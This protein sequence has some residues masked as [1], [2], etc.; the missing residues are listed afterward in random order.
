MRK[1]TIS[2]LMVA[3]L[4]V[5]LVAGCA[6][7]AVAPSTSA[8]TP[9]APTPQAALDF[10]VVSPLTGPMAD[11]GTNMKNG[12]L[13]A[14]EDQNQEGGVTVAGQKYTINAV[15]RDSKADVVVG[16][17][18]AEEL[19][20]DK[21]IKVIGGPF[22]GD[23]VGVQSITEKNKVI[24][25]FLVALISGIIGPNKPFSFFYGQGPLSE[26][27]L[28]SS[29]TQKFY[30]EAKTV[31]S[32][33]TDVADLPVF[34][35]AAK[36]MAE[37]YGLNWLGYEKCPLTTTDFTPIITRVLAKKPDIVDTSN[38]GGILGGQ[39][40][41]MV[42]QLRQQGF[43]GIIWIPA[44]PPPGALQEVVPR[45]YLN[46]IV[47][48]SI[49]L[50]SPIVA[51]AF[52]DLGK[53]YQKEYNQIPAPVI[54]MAYDP[55]K[56]FFEFLNTQDTMDTT[57]WME[58]FAKYHWQGIWGKEAFWVGKPLYGIDRILLG[59]RWV[60]EWTDGKLD[61]KWEAPLPLE[62]WIEQ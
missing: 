57:T 30:P 9:S 21:K 3:I 36:S 44:P 52:R 38:V 33:I 1:S 19:V 25:F 23:A 28:A 46:R 11:L 31:V 12:I 58:G 8:P 39:C 5:V 20:F 60:S 43:E 27:L 14:I 22:M 61:T 55:I 16:R 6:A 18:I 7:P 54:A 15:V 26:V 48:L 42:K 32:I 45:E 35:D 13:M 53:R 17:N 50:D 41:V 34:A 10:G 24:S 59:S 4:A 62:L 40:A 2:I 29:Y 49:N 51:Q 37:R 56:N 47:D